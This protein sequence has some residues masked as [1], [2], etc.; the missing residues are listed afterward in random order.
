MH[1][2]AT[3]AAAAGD[4]RST[5]RSASGSSAAADDR[6]ARRNT[7]VLAAAQSIGGIAGPVNLSISALA[8][9]ALLDSASPRTV[10]IVLAFAGGAILTMLATTMMPEAS[11]FGSL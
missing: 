2:P 10:A 4:D 11:L 7:M 1:K 6:L 9:Y 3:Q 8:G 5:L